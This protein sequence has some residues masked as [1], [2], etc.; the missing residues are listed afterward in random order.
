MEHWLSGW[1]EST[2]ST[3]VRKTTCTGTI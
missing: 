2:W 3:L 1:N